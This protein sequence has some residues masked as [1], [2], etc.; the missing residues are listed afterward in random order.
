MK[1]KSKKQ[2][3][4]P[5]YNYA[6]SGYYF[7]TLV[8]KNRHEYFSIIKDGNIILT[9]IGK[10]IKQSWLYIPMSSPFVSLDEYVVM[11]NH[12]HGILLIDNPNED[13][14]LKEKKFEIRKNSRSVVMRTFKAATTARARKLNPNIQLW[15]SRFYDR[16]I[17]NEKELQNVRKYIKDNPLQWEEDCKNAVNIMM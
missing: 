7:V 5:Y 17:R 12:V 16:I 15:Q 2:Y 11:P 9:D 10:I 13:L 3:R 1:Y 14:E 6:S 8:A 4:L